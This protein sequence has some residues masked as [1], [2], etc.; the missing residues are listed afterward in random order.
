MDRLLVCRRKL[1]LSAISLL[2][3]AP[4]RASAYYQIPQLIT[5]QFIVVAVFLQTY[6]E[7]I[8]RLLPTSETLKAKLIDHITAELSKAGITIPVGDSSIFGNP[9]EGIH[10]S[11]IVQVRVRIDLDRNGTPSKA[12]AIGSASISFERN[13][14]LHWSALPFTLF[15][16]DIS[17]SDLADKCIDAATD[18]V[19][20]TIIPQI[21]AEHRN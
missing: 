10:P 11:N 15:T 8:R 20:H 19:D 3:L 7:E 21:V 16:A 5:P 18:Q 1:L 2:S 14:D 13:G 6:D 12:S 9:I 17:A 4:L